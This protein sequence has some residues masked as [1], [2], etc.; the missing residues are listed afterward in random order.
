MA[1]K[2]LDG[3]GGKLAEGRIALILTPAFLFW[4]G[5]FAAAT[6]CD[7]WGP[8][9]HLP[10]FALGPLDSRLGLATPGR[11][12][13]ATAWFSDLDSVT[14]LVLAGAVLVLVVVSGEIAQSFLPTACR[15]AQGWW[16][17]GSKGWR[18]GRR[19]ASTWRPTSAQSE[20][21]ECEDR[22][23]DRS[24]IEPQDLTKIDSELW[25]QRARQ[26]QCAANGLRRF[27]PCCCPSIWEA[28]GSWASSSSPCLRGG[29]TRSTRRLRDLQEVR[30][31]STRLLVPVGRRPAGQRAEGPA[32]RP[33]PC[34]RRDLSTCG[35][36]LFMVR[37]LF[38]TWA[39]PAG[40]GSGRL[41]LPLLPGE[42]RI[43]IRP[44]LQRHLRRPPAV[45]LRG[46]A[47][48]AAAQPRRRSRERPEP[49]TVPPGKQTRRSATV[50]GEPGHNDT[51]A[52]QHPHRR[53]WLRWR[54]GIE[55][56]FAKRHLAASLS[57][58]IGDRR[59]YRGDWWVGDDGLWHVELLSPFRE[60]F[61]GATLAQALG[62]CLVA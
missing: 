33:R 37:G 16:P 40:C 42:C 26:R 49:V 55:R 13:S 57:A 53:R 32:G 28:S 19:L 54:V 5:G 9:A 59:G 11:M 24:K 2:F 61:G 22:C 39:V 18:G 43:G 17:D 44:D 62:W 47:L 51:A 14:L 29:A 56:T 52:S 31:R 10:D 41:H 34:R 7:S 21:R 12:R 3:P 46:V 45:A 6:S 27:R 23:R 36:L 60:T 4:A 50:H 25:R 58:A 1:T 15:W 20:W 48:A 35:G 30:T 8:G 38:A